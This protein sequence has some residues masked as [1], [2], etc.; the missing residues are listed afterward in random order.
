MKPLIDFSAF[1]CDDIEPNRLLYHL[2]FRKL[3]KVHRTYKQ[4]P[5]SQVV[6]LQ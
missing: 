6:L 4:T 2:N 3:N 1:S 5:F